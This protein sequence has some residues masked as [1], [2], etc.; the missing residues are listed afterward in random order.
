MSHNENIKSNFKIAQ[1]SIM[2]L[3]FS[4]LRLRGG[5]CQPL[6]INLLGVSH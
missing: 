1:I 4:I 3:T 2:K 5:T 6:F